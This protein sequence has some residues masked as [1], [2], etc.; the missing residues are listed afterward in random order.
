MKIKLGSFITD[1][2]LKFDNLIN[3]SICKI[4]YNKVKKER[5]WNKSLFLP[6]K[7][8]KKDKMA[9]KMNPGKNIQNLIKKYNLDFVEKNKNIIFILNKILGKNYNILLPKFVV[10]VPKNWI[11]G[12]VKKLN[13]KEPLKNFNKYIKKK[14]RDVTYFRGLDFHMDSIDWESKNNKFI[15]MYIYLN[16]VNSSMSP[17]E[18]VKRSHSLGHTSH[19][20]YI[21]NYSRKYLEYSKNNKKFYKFEKE[22][23]T[24]AA[25]SVYFWTSNTIHGTSPEISKDDNFRI[26]LR[27]IIEKKPTSKGLID[28]IIHENK[29]GKT[30]KK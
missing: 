5:K 28:K 18:I 23:L 11:P 3:P 12:Y 19:P 1:G 16:A 10:A 20:H 29:V 21:R 26:S 24:G 6:E 7:Q 2:F 30:R 25:G 15:T 4:L 22:T 8:F 14:F 27:Y 9:K 17:L 13:K